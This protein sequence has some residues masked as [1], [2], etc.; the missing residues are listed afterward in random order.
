MHMRAQ[1]INARI[2][3]S[4]VAFMTALIIAVAMPMMSRAAGDADEFPMCW[5]GSYI[6]YLECVEVNGGSTGE[7]GT[8]S[9]ARPAIVRDT[10]TDY[11]YMEQNTWGENFD[12][13]RLIQPSYFP[14]ADEASLV[15][16][17]I[18]SY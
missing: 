18:P 4:V 5:T 16:N 15:H 11:A 8:A 2:I 14:T 17:G 1:S 7:R 12:S 6:T 3:L 10:I 13:T 9:V